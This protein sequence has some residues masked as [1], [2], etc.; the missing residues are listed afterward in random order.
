MSSSV[1]WHRAVAGAVRLLAAA[2][3]AVACA[4]ARHAVPA[5][6]PTPRLRSGPRSPSDRTLEPEELGRVD[7]TES[8]YDAILT[9][10][11]QL[12]TFRGLRPSVYVDGVLVGGGTAAL[13]DIPVAWVERVRLLSADETVLLYA[14][15]PG[16]VAMQVTTRRAAR[17]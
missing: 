2:S 7:R 8:L 9:L 17:P 14:A 16:G 10:R 12:L 13:R 5:S 15:P 1:R 6:S 3:V 11:P 4:R